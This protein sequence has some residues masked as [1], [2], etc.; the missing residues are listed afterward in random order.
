VIGQGDLLM[1]DHDRS[2][3][4]ISECARCGRSQRA[5]GDWV[6]FHGRWYCEDC[7]EHLA[8][9]HDC[10]GTYSTATA[11]TCPVCAASDADLL[12]TADRVQAASVEVQGKIDALLSWLEAEHARIVAK[13]GTT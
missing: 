9:C 2:D 4:R 3:A 12:A 8:Y 6:E 13:W 10:G 1:R 5:D 11:P 7:A